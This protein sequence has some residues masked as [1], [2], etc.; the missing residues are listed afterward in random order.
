MRGSHLKAVAGK[1]LEA[2]AISRG[3]LK[4]VSKPPWEMIHRRY[5]FK[6]EDGH[7]KKTSLGTKMWKC[8]GLHLLVTKIQP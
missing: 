2:G 7:V 8:P 1:Y 6:S 3:S 4:M 5:S